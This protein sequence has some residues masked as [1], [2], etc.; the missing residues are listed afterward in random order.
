ML[1]F[2]Y[3]KK[4]FSLFCWKTDNLIVFLLLEVDTSKQRNIY[5][6]Q[7]FVEE[8]FF[9][10]S[11]PQ[12]YIHTHSRTNNRK[13]ISKKY[14]IIKLEVIASLFIAVCR[15]KVKHV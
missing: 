11:Q 6:V 7:S 8:N 14:K 4:K 2:L 3:Q 9:A 5:F 12:I 15:I 10:N 13:A 1:E